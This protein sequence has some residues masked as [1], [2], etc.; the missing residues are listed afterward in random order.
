MLFNK[1]NKIDFACQSC[2]NCCK[3]FNINITHLDIVRILENRP[4][5]KLN[6]FIEFSTAEKGDTESFI[7][8]Y[9]KRQLTLKKKKEKNECVFLVDNICSIHDFK[10][11]V[12]KVWPFSLEKNDKID[13]IQEHKSFIKKKCGHISIKGTND[14]DKLKTLIKQHYKERKAFEKIV[15]KWNTEKKSFLK[16]GDVF[17]ELYDN[18]FLEFLFKESDIDID[19]FIKKDVILEET[20]IL[21]LE[22]IP[23]PKILNDE[24]LETNLSETIKENSDVE[25]N[26]IEVLKKEQRIELITK[27]NF[28]ST[29]YSDFEYDIYIKKSNIELFKAQ[30]NLVELKQKLN[31]IDYCINKSTLSFFIDGYF[32]NINIKAFSDL[33]NPLSYDTEILYNPNS[34]AIYQYNFDLQKEYEIANIYK[35]FDFKVIKI[36]SLLA[37]NKYIEAQIIYNS[38]INQELRGLFFWTNGKNLSS[39]NINDYQAKFPNLKKLFFY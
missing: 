12:C 16:S 14:P 22:N 17:F 33:K 5:L 19:K 30:I 15:Q 18:D 27:S 6:D 2:G 11:R 36:E 1:E 20:E 25:N 32:L 35:S 34:Y 10:P 28:L 9:G 29:S 13:W 3:F 23:K 37:K 38:L 31:A 26:L 8:T 21:D 39:I 4:D 7:S 24:I